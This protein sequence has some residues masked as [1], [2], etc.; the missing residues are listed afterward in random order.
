MANKGKSKQPT[1]TFTTKGF[2]S[3]GLSVGEKTK[4]TL[5]SVGNKKKTLKDLFHDGLK[6][7]FSAEKQLVEALPKMEEAAHNEELKSAFADHLEQTKKQQQRLE[8][9]M[10]HLGVTGDE[11]CEAME[12]LI[13]EGEEIIQ[14]YPEGSVRDAALIIGAQKV[15]HYEI[16][17]YGS[18]CE[19]ADV[20]GLGKIH[21]VLGR[22]LNEEE[23]TDT[24]LSEIAQDINDEAYDEEDFD[25]E[26]DTSF[27]ANGNG[28]SSKTKSSQNKK[29]K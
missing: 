28:M 25:L 23:D 16:A 1:K 17:S 3:D 29:K 27:K 18:L 19:L 6:D 7:I 15:E 8:K 24:L 5:T 26:E 2:S 12:G 14:N 21:D 20:L 4:S 9:I 10:Q 13:K 22:S 11:N